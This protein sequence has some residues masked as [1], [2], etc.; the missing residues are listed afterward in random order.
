ME[1]VIIATEDLIT[2]HPCRLVFPYIGGAQGYKSTG[3][4]DVAMQ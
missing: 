3:T 2:V 4:R 1:N